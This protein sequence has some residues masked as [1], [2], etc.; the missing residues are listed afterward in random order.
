MLHRNNWT[1]YVMGFVQYTDGL[2]LTRRTHFC[3]KFAVGS[4]R[5][6]P[7]EDNDYEYED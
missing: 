3:R 5:F 7:E 2:V 1:L 4:A 6:Q